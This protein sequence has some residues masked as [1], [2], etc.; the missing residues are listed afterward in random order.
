MWMHIGID[1]V[2][3]RRTSLYLPNQTRAEVFRELYQRILLIAKRERT[4]VQPFT[5][6]N[7]SQRTSH[8]ISF[9]STSALHPYKRVQLAVY[10]T[11]DDC[12]LF[13]LLFDAY[14]RLGIKALGFMQMLSAEVFFEQGEARPGFTL[15]EKHET[16][17]RI[18]AILLV[19]PGAGARFVNEGLKKTLGEIL[20]DIDP[21][22]YVS[23]RQ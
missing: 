16:I 15:Y 4:P 3:G 5:H 13:Q 1:D 10:S 14:D 19:Y 11:H 21:S 2:T 23:T 22:R 20:D 6:G 8:C 12:L 9:E 17:M 7:A 18:L